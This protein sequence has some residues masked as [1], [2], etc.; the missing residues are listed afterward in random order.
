M[1]NTP[2]NGWAAFQLAPPS[3]VTTTALPPEGAWSDWP[4]ATQYCRSAHE[5]SFRTPVP[6]GTAWDLQVFPPF[7]VAMTAA[8]LSVA[9]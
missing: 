1:S 9:P 3:V 4:T 2:A 8:G 5:T 6:G 7:V